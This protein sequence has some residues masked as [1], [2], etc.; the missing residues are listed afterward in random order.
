MNRDLL[1]EKENA[2]ERLC[3]QERAR[4]RRLCKQPHGEESSSIEKY[5]SVLNSS[6]NTAYILESMS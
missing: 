4:L 1:V 6:N 5:E 3:L 2:L